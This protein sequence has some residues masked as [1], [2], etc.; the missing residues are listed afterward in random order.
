[1]NAL[2]NKVIYSISLAL[3]VVTQEKTLF[4]LAF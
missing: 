2:V 1:M 3:V 4:G